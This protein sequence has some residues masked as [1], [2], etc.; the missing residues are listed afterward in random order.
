M[1]GPRE[2]GV[3]HH[4]KQ[5]HKR[6]GM[7]TKKGVKRGSP[8]AKREG[9]PAAPEVCCGVGKKKGGGIER[10]PLGKRKKKG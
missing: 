7:K 3:L 6:R 10:N 4:Q 8:P 2:G 5:P 1:S 9:S